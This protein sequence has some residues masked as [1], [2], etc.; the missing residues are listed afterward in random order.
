MLYHW[1]N[2][3]ESMTSYTK[4]WLSQSFLTSPN[5]GLVLQLQS[6]VFRKGIVLHRRTAHTGD[7][8]VHWC[9]DVH[10]P[11]CRGLLVGDLSDD[12]ILGL[13]ERRQKNV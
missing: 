4:T 10:L 2:S 13:C 1:T 6:V 12:G 5:K 9:G 8:E 3:G 7:H 11:H